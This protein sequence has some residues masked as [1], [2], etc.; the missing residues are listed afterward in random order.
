MDIATP[1]IIEGTFY[2]LTT[3][4]GWKKFVF[5]GNI[6]NPKAFSNLMKSYPWRVPSLMKMSIFK[7]WPNDGAIQAPLL[8]LSLPSSLH[9]LTQ[10][11][12]QPA[13]AG[14]QPWWTQVAW[15]LSSLHWTTDQ[16]GSISH[17]GDERCVGQTDHKQRTQVWPVGSRISQLLSPRNLYSHPLPAPKALFL[18]SHPLSEMLAFLD[19]E[20]A[21]LPTSASSLT[22]CQQL[23]EVTMNGILSLLSEVL[24]SLTLSEL[25]ALSKRKAS[26]AI[27]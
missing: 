1:P 3:K 27:V 18:P 19:Q 26:D 17:I 4:I 8:L 10:C 14:S 2:F 16:A 25:A 6:S 13:G 24:G 15:H 22:E 23:R 21:I 9:F 12:L 5:P 20:A 7:G 11:P